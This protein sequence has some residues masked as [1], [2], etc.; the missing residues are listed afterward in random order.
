MK[1]ILDTV[2]HTPPCAIEKFGVLEGTRYTIEARENE[3]RREH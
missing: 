2:G 1:T 3:S